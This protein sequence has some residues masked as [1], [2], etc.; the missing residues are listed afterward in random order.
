MADHTAETKNI[1]GCNVEVLRGGEGAKLL[2]LHGAGGAN[3]WAP[4]MDALAENFDLIVPSHPGFGNSDTPDWLDNLS[5]LAFF[6]LDFMA[7]YDLDDIHLVGNSLGGW[8]AA[9][10]AVR[11]T[12]RIK[13]LTLVSAAGLHVKGVPKGDLFLWNPETRVR[14]TFHDQKLADAKLAIEVSPEQA[15][16]QLKNHFTTA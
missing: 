1:N 2:F 10:I 16:I 3:I 6:Y 8:I 15:D 9:E 13:T 4:Y 5:D 14:N 12:A 11:S 7:A